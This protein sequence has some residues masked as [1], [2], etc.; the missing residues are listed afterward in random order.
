MEK[1][2]FLFVVLIGL[3]VAKAQKDEDLTLPEEVKISQYLNLDNG[4]D[5][6][7]WGPVS[8]CPNGTF[9]YALEVKYEDDDDVDETAVNAIK[10]YCGD[11]AGGDFGY[12]TSSEGQM[13]FWNGMRNCSDSFLMGMRGLVVE[14]QGLFEDDVAVD[15]VQMMCYN[16]TNGTDILTG[17]YDDDLEPDID[18]DDDNDDDDGTW[19]TWALCDPGSAI[20]GIQTRYES[21]SLM[22]DVAIADFTMFCCPMGTKNEMEEEE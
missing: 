3:A 22:D 19:S 14:Y 2:F 1:G 10:L 4:F 6:G 11:E 15:N 9:A 18:D 16:G 12:V 20:C 8:L 21:P 7:E 13:G 5:A 17:V